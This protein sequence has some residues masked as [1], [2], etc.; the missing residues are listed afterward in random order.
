MH[1]ILPLFSIH[2]RK[3]CYSFTIAHSTVS[4]IWKNFTDSRAFTLFSFTIIFTAALCFLFPPVTSCMIDSIS[5]SLFTEKTN[6]TVTWFDKFL[7]HPGWL[8]VLIIDVV[9][10]PIVTNTKDIYFSYTTPRLYDGN[11]ECFFV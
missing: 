6:F 2:I 9:S 4:R 7:S 10:S 3:C 1:H 11:F 8:L 5:H